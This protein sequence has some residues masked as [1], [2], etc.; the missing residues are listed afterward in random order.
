MSL[1]A[2]SLLE[3]V[4]DL[5]VRPDGT[6]AD[7]QAS[8]GTVGREVLRAL[9][10]IDRMAQATIGAAGASGAA[11]GGATT[12]TSTASLAVQ[13]PVVLGVNA[14]TELCAA[15]ARNAQSL[16]GPGTSIR[17]T[18]RQTRRR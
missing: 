14:T 17:P 12:V 16:I 11:A 2:N 5:T 3:R 7:D 1:R 18:G 8:R 15:T 4:R 10:E 6:Q 13:S 9:D